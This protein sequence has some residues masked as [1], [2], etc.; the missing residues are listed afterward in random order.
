QVIRL[1]LKQGKFTEADVP[2]A[3]T[4]LVC[5]SIA[6]FAWSASAILSRGFLAL[7]ETRTPVLVTTPMVFLFAALAG[8]YMA[9]NPEGFIGLPLGTSFV[10]ILTCGLLLYL[11]NRRVQHLN[12]HAIARSTLKIAVA[13][14]AAGFVGHL[15]AGRFDL[16][17]APPTHGTLTG[18]L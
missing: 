10:G 11:L 8:V 14:L 16:W 12:L 15:V 9:P 1:F 13:S 7:Q 5:Y 3:A 2:M 4:A 6:T 18:K 17:F